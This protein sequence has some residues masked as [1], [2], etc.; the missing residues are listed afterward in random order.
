L[1][2]NANWST[3]ANWMAGTAPVNGD[4]LVFPPSASQLTNTD[5]LGAGFTFGSLT[6]SGGGYSIS[7]SNGSTASFTSIDSSQSSPGSNT[8]NLPISSSATTTVTVDAAGS[9]LVWGGVI[10]G[11]GGLTTSGSGTLNLTANNTY[12]GPTTVGGGTLLINGTQTA[13]VVVVNSTA[14]LGGTGSVGSINAAGATVIP[15]NPAPGVLTD[16]GALTLGQDTENN[17]STFT[18]VLDGT[19]PGSGTGKYSQLQANG[20]VNL[21]G[22]TLSGTLGS[23]FV[24]TVGSTY[25]IIDSTGSAPLTGTFHGQDEGSIVEFSG[26]PFRI[27]Y[28][29]GTNHNSVVLTELNPSTISTW[30]GMG[31]DANWSTGGNWMSGTAPVAGNDLIFPASASKLTNTDNLGADFHFNSLTLAGSGYSISASNSSTA[32]F[33]IIDASQ[34]TGSNTVSIP[35]TLGGPTSVA[36]DNSGASL[37]L[38]GLITGSSALTKSGAGTLNLSAD[39]TYTGTTKVDGGTLRIDGSQASS[40]VT[41]NSGATLGGIGTVG[42][43]A[44]AGGTVNP[45]DAAPGILVDSGNA[46]LGADATSSNS[47]FVVELDGSTP[48]NGTGKYSQLQVGGTINLSGV[49]LSGTLGPD[50]T[51]TL[52]STYTIIDNTGSAAISGTFAGQA[53]GSIILISGTPFSIS[54]TGG[55]NDHS[56]VLTEKDASTTTVTFTPTS[57][58][59]GQSIGLTA[60]VTGPS[61]GPTPTGT[62]QFFNGTTSLGTETLTNGTFTL[63]TSALPVATNSITAVYSGDSNYGPSTATAVAVTVAQASTTTT[64]TPSTTTPA[65]GQSVMF[66]ATVAPASPG[67]GSPTGTVQFFNGTTSLGTETLS[68]GVATLTTSALPIGTNSIT[69]TYSGDTNFTTSASTAVTVTVAQT[70]TT[71]TLAISNISPAPFETVNL[72]ATVGVIS[73]GTGTPTG[74]VEFLVNGSSVGTS[75]INNGKATLSVVPPI[76]VD[77]VTAQYLGNGNFATSTSAAVTVSVGTAD[78]Q[79]INAVY[80]IELGRAPTASDLTSWNEQFAKGRTRK[81]IVHQIA[82]S[83]EANLTLIQSIFQ[84][85][86]GQDGTPAQIE[87]AVET[88]D[89][90]HTSVRAA[91]LGSRAFYQASG[92]TPSSYLAA[93]EVAVLGNAPYAPLLGEQL[94]NGV[95]P[96]QIAEQL[97]LSTPSKSNLLTASFQQVL[98]RAPTAAESVFYVQLMDQGVFLRQ[99]VASLLAGNEFFKKATTAPSST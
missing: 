55:T 67:A 94:A 41:V 18:V 14:T 57:P 8:V 56:V 85:Y 75:T 2:T 61:G 49:T 72:T 5:D 77:A 31:S 20:P 81:D 88:A 87:R 33:N 22:V 13:S 3:G 51:P 1:G 42:S 90:T 65:F 11:S 35:I 82:T 16:T 10:S 7:A 70:A 46:K 78:E 97:L 89:S 98:G 68:S 86:L 73:P 74:T 27:S 25:T 52:G 43:I 19:T 76:G 80:S 83:P 62:V 92:G 15:G 26:T 29:G 21:S 47:K 93:L 84:Q 96:V 79:Y 54:Y 6:F 66:K 24:P 95:S 4:S 37:V 12:T 59:F 40:A 34:S 39:N 28:V 36:V 23:G 60:T 30:T 45:G 91:V 9:A 53:Q 63:N 99:I 38:S 64:V 50:F 69:A 44:A 48:G 32:S 17:N 71:T 58:V